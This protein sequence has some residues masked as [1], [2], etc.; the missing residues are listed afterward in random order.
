MERGAV[1]EHK[2][3]KL[4][5]AHL[6]REHLSSSSTAPVPL[7]LC[8][9]VTWQAS[10][11]VLYSGFSFSGCLKAGTPRGLLPPV[12]AILRVPSW[13]SPAGLDE[14]EELEVAMFL[15]CQRGG[16][17]QNLKEKKVQ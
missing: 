10:K 17:N 16:S 12:G 3:P 2:G 11:V 7:V 14:R 13:R 9:A 5:C 6:P 8:K 4:L 1:R 15:E